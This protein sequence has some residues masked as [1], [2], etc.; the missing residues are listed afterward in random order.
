[1][2]E[3]LVILDGSTVKAVCEHLHRDFVN[4]FRYALVWGRSA[5]F[6]GQ[7]VGL[8]HELKDCDVLSIITKRR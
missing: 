4:L 5:K 7:S 1:M 6:P 8:E 2:E 3:P